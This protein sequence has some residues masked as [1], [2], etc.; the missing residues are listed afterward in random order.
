MKILLT[1][2]VGFI[3]LKTAKKLVE[4]GHEVVA[5]DSL[6]EQ[7]HQDIESEKA[8]FPGKIIVGDVALPETW[9]NLEG[10]DAIIHLAAE[11]GTAQSMYETE[12]YRSVNVDGTRYAAEY[13]VKWNAPLVSLSSR[14]VYGEGSAERATK[15]SDPHKPLSVYGETKSEGEDIVRE[16]V[17]GKV[18]ATIVRPQNVIGPG[19]ALH[20]PYTGVLAAFLARLRE[21]KNL[22]VY[23]DGTQTRDFIHVEDVADILIWA[24]TNLPELDESPRIINAGSG[25]RITLDQ[26]AQYSIDA[27]PGGSEAII[28]H[29]DIKRAGDIDHALADMSYAYSLGAPQARWSARE[30][31]ADFIQKSWKAPG[32]DSSA[33][34]TA[35]EEL[36]ER[37]LAEHND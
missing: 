22:S 12:R 32:A 17:A 33:W 27:V 18:P 8:Q 13:A 24:L 26:L 29:V 31:I 15:E 10:A 1:G 21:G 36:T 2:G 23:G 11:T 16:V 7:V 19:Q 35:L 14:A 5:L 4:Q 6:L 30:A 37:G 9:E 3:G 25:E 28:E 34:E 20:N